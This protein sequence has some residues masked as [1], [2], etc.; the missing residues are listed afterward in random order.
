M[1]PFFHK[2][3]FA[4]WL[5][6]NNVFINASELIQKVYSFS[7]FI[8]RTIFDKLIRFYLSIC[9][10]D[11]VCPKPIH[12]FFYEQCFFSAQPQCCLTFWWFKSQMLLK[13][14]LLYADI[15]LNK[16]CYILYICAHVY[17]YAI[18]WSIF[19]YHFQFYCNYSHNLNK[20]PPLVYL[21]I[22]I[23]SS[24]SGCCLAFA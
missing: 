7:R 12:A 23:K 2:E 10:K 1:N 6:L 14:C 21:D 9:G 8:I 3:A 17:V 16:V 15:K 4:Q 13:C 20:N 19:Y 11:W 5:S 24:A 22:F 18:I